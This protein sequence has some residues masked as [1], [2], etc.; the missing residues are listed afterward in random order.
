LRGTFWILGEYLEAPDI[1]V[2]AQELIRQAIGG[3]VAVHA[4]ETKVIHKPK[5]L[6]D[7]TYATESAITKEKAEVLLEVPSAPLRTLLNGGDFYIGSVVATTLV[8]LSMRYN[9]TASSSDANVFRGKCMLL[10]TTMIRLGKAL[11]PPI[12]ED[13]FSRIITC[14]RVLGYYPP[15]QEIMDAFTREPRK[16]FANMLHSKDALKEKEKTQNFTPAE[17]LIPFR[18]LKPKKQLLDAV[19]TGF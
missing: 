12:D 19:S 8:K 17:E 16:A 1:I 18:L 3:E 9:S 10:L 14:I 15:N 2:E 5:I 13:S 7:G 6:S 11:S 4:E